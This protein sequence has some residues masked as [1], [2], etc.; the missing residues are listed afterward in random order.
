MFKVD[1]GTHVMQSKVSFPSH[2]TIK[3]VLESPAIAQVTNY[4]ILR[5]K[6]PVSQLC[7]IR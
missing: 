7:I 2:F 3:E 5:R 4:D 1:K 6:I